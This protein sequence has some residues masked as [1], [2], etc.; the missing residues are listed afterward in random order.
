M[1]N[2]HVIK[3]C[4][5]EV[6]KKTRI[7]VSCEIEREG[8]KPTDLYFKIWNKNK[9][10]LEQVRR[11]E[12]NKNTLYKMNNPEPEEKPKEPEEKPK[13]PELEPW[14]R[15]LKARGVS[16]HDSLKKELT[17]D[18]WIKA[19][20][21]QELR[22]NKLVIEARKV[23]DKEIQQELHKIDKENQDQLIKKNKIFWKDHEDE[24]QDLSVTET[25]IQTTKGAVLFIS[26]TFEE[27]LRTFRKP[28]EQIE[29]ER[30]E[31]QR[32]QQKSLIGGTSD[33]RRSDRR[34]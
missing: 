17:K 14:E 13:E 33:R 5:K 30:R 28:Q 31:R 25:Y 1:L 11:S 19:L 26:P 20:R 15:E 21:N 22:E 23:R 32:R 34:D 27:E 8:R 7:N 12:E 10:E 4:L 3:K 2:I 18:H 9:K 24:Y 6:N 16:L 29:E